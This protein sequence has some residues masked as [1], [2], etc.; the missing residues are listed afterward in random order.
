MLQPT[1]MQ[2]LNPLKAAFSTGITLYI[3]SVRF[4]IPHCV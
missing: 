2:Q 1:P 4:F 3:S